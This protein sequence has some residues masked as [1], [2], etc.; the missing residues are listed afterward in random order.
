MIHR[1]FL[2][3][4]L[5]LLWCYPA[6]AQLQED[7]MELPAT[8]E[9]PAEE[10]IAIESEEEPDSGN[11]YEKLHW[12]KE[13]KRVYTVDIHDIMEQLKQIAHDYEEKKKTILEKVQKSV[14]TI[15]VTAQA[16]GPIIA[17]YLTDLRA[18][19]DRLLEGPV[20]EQ[21]ETI[22]FIDEQEKV[23]EILKQD[24][25]D[26]Q[27]LTSHLDEAYNQVFPKQI[28]ECES[29]EERALDN[30]ERIENVLD[31]KKAHHYYDIVENS[32]ENIRALVQYLIGP[33]QIF[34]DDTAARIDV[35]VPK[36]KKSIE[37]LEKADIIIRILSEQ[38]KA[39]RA[40][41]LKKKEEARLKAEA[42]KIEQER[43]KNMSWLKKL[44]YLIG[45]FFYALWSGIVSAFS[46]IGSLFTGGGKTAAPTKPPSPALPVKPA[47]P[48]AK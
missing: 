31:D 14:A 19:R 17:Q 13:A 33:L 12:W 2:A 30:F 41:M 24:F 23:L 1:Y 38:E 16:A 26:L 22:S 6:C 47:P 44:F 48:V 37:D 20:P 39:E 42:E 5:L 29:Y 45:S 8:Y 7:A 43:W 21:R 9:E 15:P 32:L 3:C 11:W 28:K 46:W 35:I 34:I 25:Q 36:I 10:K 27:T 18:Q 40:A 4:A